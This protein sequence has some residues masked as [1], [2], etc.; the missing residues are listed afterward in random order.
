MELVETVK[1]HANYISIFNTVVDGKEQVRTSDVNFSDTFHDCKMSAAA[2]KQ[3]KRGV[4]VILYLARRQHFAQAR[5][6]S[7]ASCTGYRQNSPQIKKRIA[8]TIKEAEKVENGKQKP[9]SDYLCTFITLTLPAGQKHTDKE[10]TEYAVNPFLSYARKYWGVRYYIWKKELQSNGNLHFH[11][12]T[13][14]Y[15]EANKL[16]ECWNR[17]LNRGAVDGCST[18]FDYVDRYNATMRER[19]ADGWNNQKMW[20]FVKSS[21]YVQQQS[22]ETATEAEAKKNYPLTEEEKNA[23]FLLTAQTYFNK[24]YKSY[25]AEILKPEEERWRDP[26]STDV[27]A[28]HTPR[29]VSFYVAKYIAKDIVSNNAVSLYQSKVED[30]K[31]ELYFALREI[32]R[33]LSEGET[34]TEADNNTVNYYRNLLEEERKHCPIQ[35]KL[36]FKSATLTPF[37]NGATDFI[38]RELYADLE[39]LYKYLSYLEEKDGKKYIV[40]TYQIDEQGKPTDKI[41]C[42]TLLYNIFSLQMQKSKKGEYKFPELTTMWFKFVHDCIKIN[43]QRGLYELSDKERLSAEMA[44]ETA[45]NVKN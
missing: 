36:W 40:R 21:D 11:F 4:N 20:E 31:R 38:N 24:L 25:N 22:D 41:L 33:K 35:G 26:N 45:S 8:K 7:G 18:V 14:R 9:K 16:R 28:V 10:L 15:V 2:C 43:K 29:A 23:I 39:R 12:C 13:D 1:L 27:R 37:C 17:I 44:N 5:R 6:L 3:I 34:V 42:T 32:K 19:Y 30:I